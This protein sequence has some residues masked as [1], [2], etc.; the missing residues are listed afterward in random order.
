MVCSLVCRGAR[1]EDPFRGLRAGPVRCPP[2]HFEFFALSP[3]SRTPQNAP[4]PPAKVCTHSPTLKTNNIARK[5]GFG[6]RNKRPGAKSHAK[7]LAG[8]PGR[9][10]SATR[11]ARPKPCPRVAT[12][13]FYD[14][15]RVT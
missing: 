8:A 7:N 6:T 4:E 3:T 12:P 9:T 14:H 13:I 10:H 15:R 1:A 5:S 11:T 2:F